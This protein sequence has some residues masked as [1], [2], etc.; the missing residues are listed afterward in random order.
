MGDRP[1]MRAGPASPPGASLLLSYLSF[2]TLGAGRVGQVGPV[3]AAFRT[4]PAPRWLAG[5][6]KKALR[7]E[8]AG[9]RTEN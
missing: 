2:C 1:A 8:T 9:I 6:Q 7:S 3:R 4:S 5:S